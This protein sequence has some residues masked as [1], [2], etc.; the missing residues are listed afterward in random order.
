MN[1]CREQ[2]QTFEEINE[3]RNDIIYRLE[4]ENSGL[5]S[6]HCETVYSTMDQSSDVRFRNNMN[7]VG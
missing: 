2:L 6:R 5:K 4:E 1:T 7:H 3:A